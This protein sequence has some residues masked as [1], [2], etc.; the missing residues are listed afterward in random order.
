M[1]TPSMYEISPLPFMNSGA[2][3]PSI[4]SSWSRGILKTTTI[5]SVLRKT[6]NSQEVVE[7]GLA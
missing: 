4:V 3:H 2:D 7:A 5:S 1:T 6:E